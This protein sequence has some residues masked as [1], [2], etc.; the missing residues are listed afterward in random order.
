MDKISMKKLVKGNS[1]SIS[2][3]LDTL[4]TIDIEEAFDLS[5]KF[6]EYLMLRTKVKKIEKQ[7]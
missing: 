3:L 2:V 7:S 4:A 6:L 1:E 5:S